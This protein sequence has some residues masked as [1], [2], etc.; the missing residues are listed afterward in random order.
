MRE[1]TSVVSSGGIDVGIPLMNRELSG[2]SRKERTSKLSSSSSKHSSSTASVV[3]LRSETMGSV[4]SERSSLLD[5]SS[6]TP[7][8]R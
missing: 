2:G 5:D 1:E 6:L 7:S 4:P 8:R 3:E